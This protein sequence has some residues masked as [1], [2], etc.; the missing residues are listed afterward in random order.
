VTSLGPVG[1]VDPKIRRRDFW[2]HATLFV[3]VN[4]VYL[5]L[6]WPAWLWVTAI[7]AVG[8]GVHGSLVFELPFG[9]GFPRRDSSS[10]GGG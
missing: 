9:R 10:E 2:L 4:A 3:V 5:L 6:A 7:W 1:P 8:L